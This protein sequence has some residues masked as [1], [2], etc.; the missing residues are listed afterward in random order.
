MLVEI[1][2]LREGEEVEADVCV[3]GSGPT[4][5]ALAHELQGSGRRTV[6]VES[7]GLEPSPDAARLDRGESIGASG[8]DM[9]EGR[10]RVLGG[11]STLWAGQCLPLEP[12]AFAA[13]PWVADSG[14][15]ISPAD[16]QPYVG[17]AESFFRVRGEPYDERVWSPFGLA[18]LPLDRSKLTHLATVYTPQPDLGARFREALERSPDVRVLL[19]A[20]ATGLEAGEGGRAVT[21]LRVKGLDGR[22]ARIRARAFALCAGAIENAR[23]LLLSGGIGNERDLVGRYFQ[24]HP[25]V[26]AGSVETA[27]PRALLDRYSLLYRKPHRYWAKMGAAPELQK[28]R[29]ILNGIANLKLDFGADSGLEA[30]KRL[31]RAAR[32]RERP[33]GGGR[34]LARMAR[35]LPALARAYGRFRR[36]LSPASTPERILLQVH[37][38]QAPDRESRVRLGTEL[39]PLGQPVAQVDW[40]VGDQDVETARVLSEAV[41]DELARLG[42]GEVR[43]AEWDNGAGARGFSGAYHYMGTTR[44]ADDPA[45]GVVDR[46]CAVHGVAGLYCC[47]GSVFPAGGVA[48]PTL[49]MAALALRLADHIKDETA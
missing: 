26:L 48:N 35:D 23:L 3:V 29:Q 15:P 5:M 42:A 30:A 28:E 2:E 32:R 11:A 9:D 6:L 43:L 16:L 37:V 17:R 40:R 33:A 49:A 20:T 31:Y 10:A 36:G 24:D 41:R 38:E 13:R 8:V 18:P 21:A 19:R 34:D 44:M 46:D 7:G 12:E 47:G 22:E 39:D 4:G 27:A 45:R 1:G 14:W 25:N